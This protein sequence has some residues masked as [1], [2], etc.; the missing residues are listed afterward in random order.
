MSIAMGGS[1]GDA[2]CPGLFVFPV[3]PAGVAAPG[4]CVG[5][6]AVESTELWDAVPWDAVLTPVEPDS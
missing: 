6:S 1:C 4:P 2:T 5:P 3:M